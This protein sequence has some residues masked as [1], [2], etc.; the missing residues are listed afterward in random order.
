MNNVPKFYTHR[1]AL[2]YGGFVT[3]KSIITK[4][5]EKIYALNRVCPHRA[6]LIGDVGTHSDLV[7]KF[8]G[9]A[10][11]PDGSPKNNVCRMGKKELNLGR[12]GLVFE[13]FN[14]PRS[15]EW[16]DILESEKNLVYSGSVVGKSKGSWLW[17]MDIQ[18]DLFHIRKNGI[19][20]SLADITDLDQIEM[21]QGYD[22]ILQTHN[23]G[24]FWLFI[25]PYTFVEWLPGCLSVNYTIPKNETEFGFDYVTQFF[26][27]PF[28]ST[29]DRK[30]FE[31]IDLT[32][33]EDIKAIENQV[34][35]YFPLMESSSRLEDQCVHFGNWYKEMI[36]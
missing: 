1:A 36:K 22:W 33:Q 5:E 35:P 7:C 13:N 4:H 12:S 29:K 14:E 25:Y 32:F 15:T 31:T 9:F 10:F 18:C 24:G 19:H 2:G 34:G 17:M 26:Y 20:P 3:P 8:H 6:Y 11:N 21:D 28:V 16:V 23:R 27:D 30:E